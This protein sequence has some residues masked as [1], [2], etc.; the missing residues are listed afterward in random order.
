MALFARIAALFRR[1]P[2]PKPR[3]TTSTEPE[4]EMAHVEWYAG[5]FALNGDAWEYV[6]RKEIAA[7]DK[8]RVAIMHA[9]L[10][11]EITAARNKQRQNSMQFDIGER[12]C[13]GYIV[14]D[15]PHQNAVDFGKLLGKFNTEEEPSFMF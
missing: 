5:S 13:D 14:L 7:A 8:E 11:A 9:H 15:T 12:E 10:D 3:Q 2:R 1:A 4:I 6:S